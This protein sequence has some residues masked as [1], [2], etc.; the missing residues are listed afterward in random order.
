MQRNQD[1]S[2]PQFTG[3]SRGNI[4]ISLKT[5]EKP[6]DNHLGAQNTLIDSLNTHKQPFPAAKNSQ[7]EQNGGI[8]AIM[9]SSNQIYQ[10]KEPAKGNQI[11]SKISKKA[12]VILYPGATDKSD[13]LRELKK[14]LPG[15]FGEKIERPVLFKPL[16]NPFRLSKLVENDEE[17]SWR[18]IDD[19]EN[20][21]GRVYFLKYSST[22]TA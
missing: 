6:A 12:I 16:P 14:I 1:K 18:Y 5:E 3:F 8:P 21:Q 20:V 9:R 4:G 17:R 2:K 19:S 10:R 22:R 11:V 7:N 15:A 13:S